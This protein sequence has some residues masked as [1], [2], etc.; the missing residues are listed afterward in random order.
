MTNTVNNLKSFSADSPYYG[1]TATDD[2][3]PANPDTGRDNNHGFEGLTLSTDGQTL[4]VLLQAALVQD[5]GTSSAED[6]YTRLLVYD[7]ST[8]SSPVYKAG[9]VVQLPMY[10]TGK[11]YKTAAQSEMHFLSSTQF[12]V[13]ARDSNAGRGQ[14]SSTSLYR[15]A[16]IIDISNATNIKGNT[17]DCANCTVAPAGVLNANITV[18]T[19]CPF[20]D[21]NVN[22]QLNRFGVHNGGSQDNGLLNEKWESLALVPVTPGTNDGEYFLFSMSDNDFITQNGTIISSSST[23]KTSSL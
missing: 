10:N 21:Y 15:H 16:D 11:K 1:S 14:S 19:Y 18:A 20:L 22:A 9:Y 23:Q 2:V 17:Y 7:V 5:G 6:D 3:T 4:Y 13:L 8:P 12:L